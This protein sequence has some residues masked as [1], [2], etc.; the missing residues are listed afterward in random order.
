MRKRINLIPAI[1]SV[2]LIFA[3]S[4]ILVENALTKYYKSAYPLKYSEIVLKEAKENSIDPSIL[5]S[6]I[7]TESSFNDKAESVVGA[8][9]LMQL[10]SDTFD[11]VKSKMNDNS[12]VSFDDMYDPEIN[13]KYGAFLIAYLLNEFKTFDNSLCAYHAGRGALIKWLSNSEL[14]KDGKNIFNIPYEDTKH[15]VKTVISSRKMYQK[16]YGLL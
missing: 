3:I 12:D 15:Y 11:W 1:I 14:S 16:L 13:I 8:R 7:R 10:T 9:G 6:I 2:F 4:F 5:Y